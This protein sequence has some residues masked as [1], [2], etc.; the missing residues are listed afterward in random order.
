[1]RWLQKCVSAVFV[2]VEVAVIVVMNTDV[3]GACLCAHQ[4]LS[5]SHAQL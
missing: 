2:W 4:R 5:P 3:L 1:M